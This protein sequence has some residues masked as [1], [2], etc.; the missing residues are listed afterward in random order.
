MY[1]CPLYALA[2]RS[3]RCQRGI[4]GRSEIGEDA[5]E[6]MIVTQPKVGHMLN[7]PQEN[8][9]ILSKGDL[10][11]LAFMILLNTDFCEAITVI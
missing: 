7:M 8:A 5:A 11:L 6:G 4:R 1:R 3:S 10:L 9:L 2:T